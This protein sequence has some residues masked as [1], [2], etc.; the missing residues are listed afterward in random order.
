[1]SKA[2]PHTVPPMWFELDRKSLHPTDANNKTEGRYGSYRRN[3]G[4]CA[5]DSRKG[6]TVADAPEPLR[7]RHPS[8]SFLRLRSRV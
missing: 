3:S 8:P 1:L 7:F 2:A 6:A 4:H 5:D